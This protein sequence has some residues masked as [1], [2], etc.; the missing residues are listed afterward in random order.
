MRSE[1]YSVH[2]ARDIMVRMHDGVLLATDLYRPEQDG[3]L[4]GERLPVILVRTPYD[5]GALEESPCWP[6][7]FASRGYVAVAQDCRGC[8]GSEG[9][10]DFL[11]PEADDGYDT[12][13]WI[14]AQEWC[15]GRVAMWGTSWAS[16]TQTAAAAAGAQ[17]LRALVPNMS[18]SSAHT[19][20]VRQG[21]ALELRW[22]AWAFWHATLNRR[23]SVGRLDWVDAALN[24]GSPQV[25]DWMTRL[26]LRRGSTQLHLVEP[27]EHWMLDIASRG[28]YDERWAHPSVNPVA[29]LE[30]F[31]DDLAVLLVG[32]WYDSYA[33]GTLELFE[34]LTAAANGRVHALIG[35]WTHGQA[36]VELSYAGDVEL[37]RDAALSSFL[38][39]HLDW[40]DHCLRGA[41]NQFDDWP[42]LRIF[43]MGGGPGTRTQ[44]GRLYHGGRWRDEHEWPLA[45]TAYQQ[46]Y[47]VGDG[48]LQREPSTVPPSSTTYLFNPTEP[49]PSIG[50]NI[51]SLSDLRPVAGG[52]VSAD[53]AAPG[54]RRFEIVEAGGFDQRERPGVF[55]CSPPYLPISSRPD[56]LVFET[57]PLPEPIEVTGPITVVL[58][59][60][61]TTPD[62]DF[63][64][65][66]I[67]LYP[68]SPWYPNGYALNL[69]DSIRRLRYRGGDV[70]I[71]YEPDD[72][73]KIQIDLYPT[74]N[75]FAPGHRIRLDISSS[76][77]PRFDVNPNTGD[78]LW[79]ERRRRTSENTVFHDVMHPSHVVLPVIPL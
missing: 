60:A 72:I 47:L 1:P 55:G 28:D 2:V 66:L 42:A 63:T 23:R 39:L 49:V 54:Q 16:W 12:V 44:A 68:P 7:L 37:G 31:P 50:G 3:H 40:Y 58:W 79:T 34:A 11:W 61:S 41:K 10:V 59:V 43:V 18:G 26:P 56:V 38:D 30:S 75:M 8:Y 13:D 21:G 46:L 74:S 57:A 71:D 9:D 25:T 45:R 32:G 33:R 19:S 6:Q 70:E 69:S 62:T 67:D 78:P 35:P 52:L 24:L 64:A 51:S 4:V 20:S 29:H 27:Y 14:T 77:F 73:V 5:K 36:K 22:I 15:D 76:N 53:Y 65:K 17:G 48:S